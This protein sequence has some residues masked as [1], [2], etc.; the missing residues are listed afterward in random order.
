MAPLSP[1]TRTTLAADM[2]VIRARTYA[3]SQPGGRTDF[4][5]YTGA[6]GDAIALM[7]GGDA[8]AA[9]CRAA[10]ACSLASWATTSR[11][12]WRTGSGT[13][14]CGP[15]G[16]R[17]VNEAMTGAP[18]ELVVPNTFDAN[19]TLYGRA[20]TLDALRLAPSTPKSL[21]SR[22]AAELLAA[23][24]EYSWH[25]KTYLGAAHG[26]CGIAHS[27][28]ATYDE[29]LDVR[30]PEAVHSM[31][32]RIADLVLAHHGAFPSRP[33]GSVRLTQWCHGSP[34]ALLCLMRACRAAQLFS[35]SESSASPQRWLQAARL[36][37]DHV[38]ASDPFCRA[39]GVGL[40]HGAAGNGWA[41]LSL[42]RSPWG[43]PSDEERVRHFARAIVDDAPR[44]GLDDPHSLFN[45]RGGRVC[46]LA[47]VLNET[48]MGFPA[49]DS[50]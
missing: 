13:M 2:A 19:E 41:L 37:A 38:A 16:A 36:A 24:P 8:D 40:C 26:L 49:V 34:G 50:V 18:A 6:A 47:A 14:I 45:G 44:L 4:S 7:R 48:W 1:A 33:D 39:K 32:D 43:T 28:I 23:G 46:F 21:I 12:R 11:S 17:V 29:V 15:A 9:R 35:G 10:E 27:L 20:G 30:P 31:I 5:V 25:G 3:V 22:L 42:A